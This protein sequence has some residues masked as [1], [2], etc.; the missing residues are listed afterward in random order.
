MVTYTQYN[1]IIILLYHLVYVVYSY[2]THFLE[3]FRSVKKD[4][5]PLMGDTSLTSFL[6]G[7]QCCFSFLRS[8]RSEGTAPKLLGEF[9]RKR[10]KERGCS[11]SVACDISDQYNII[12]THCRARKSYSY[13]GRLEVR[14]PGLGSWNVIH[15]S[16][17][18]HISVLVAFRLFRRLVG[19]EK[20]LHWPRPLALFC[21]RRPR[22]TRW[23]AAARG[24]PRI[25]CIPT[26][27]LLPRY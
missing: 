24:R 18:G 26:Q 2:K 14:P 3:A 19:R 20:R 4:G 22:H 10:L 21:W 5:S 17:A 11:L 15:S 16:G 9:S 13:H 12:I 1:C 25:Q 8:W 27:H 7:E 6:K 23:R